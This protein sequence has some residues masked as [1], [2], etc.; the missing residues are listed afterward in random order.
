[1]DEFDLIKTYFAPLAREFSGSLGLIDDAA[2]IAVP[3][4]Q[5]LVIT[6]DAIS[7]GVHF[8]GNENPSQLAKKLLRVNLSDLAAMGAKP[9]CYFLALM[10]PKETSE[11]WIKNFADGLAEDQ[12]E[13]SIHLAGG[14]TTSTH[15]ALS[16]SMTALGTVPA[17]KA[18][19]RSG[20]KQGDKVYVSG[21]LG[22]SALGLMALRSESK[23]DFLI[24]R[25]LLPEPRIA[26]GQKLIGT[27]TACMDISDG[28]VQ[29]LGHICRA[30]GVGATI[31]RDTLPL[32]EPA[33]ALIQKDSNLWEAPL[34][35][36][37]DYEL[38]FTVSEKNHSVL[39]TLS[40]ELHPPIMMI[41]EITEGN[42]VRAL[43]ATGN[44]ITLT[45][46]GFRHFS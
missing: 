41:G 37:D 22:D 20:A 38:L 39:E 42:G 27:A 13:F 4:G 31:Y 43:D 19:K 15:G 21:T 12:R 6:K 9:L 30:S 8:I 46:K 10:L 33:R 1:M 40:R 36:G 3:L 5:E 28:L 11:E 23:D 17:G 7:E 14:D 44:E 32:S 29:D 18:L 24:R 35:G 34:S 45:K 16:F 25:Y 26:L 2:V